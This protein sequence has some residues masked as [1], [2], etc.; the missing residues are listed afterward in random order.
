MKTIAILQVVEGVPPSSL[1]ALLHSEVQTAWEGMKAGIVRAAHYI[2]GGAD[3]VL[4]LETA[5]AAQAEAFVRARPLVAAGLIRCTTYSL[6]PYTG[7]D[8]LMKNGQR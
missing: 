8:L 2:V 3:G 1:Q 6:S 4:E 7:L 5:D